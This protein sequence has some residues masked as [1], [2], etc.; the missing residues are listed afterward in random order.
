[1]EPSSWPVHPRHPV[2]FVARADIQELTTEL[3]RA[4]K[5]LGRGR[6][7]DCSARCSNWE[8]LKLPWN[9]RLSGPISPAKQSARD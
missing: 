6:R 9:K 2:R 8:K 1:M 4:R 3:A 7:H 5:P